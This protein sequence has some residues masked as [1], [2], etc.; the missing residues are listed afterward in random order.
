MENNPKTP[1]DRIHYVSN[2]IAENENRMSRLERLL[3]A[4]HA[5]GYEYQRAKQRRAYRRRRK[6]ADYMNQ[7]LKVIRFRKVLEKF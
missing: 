6:H 5:L 4:Y 7:N 2:F 1:A 3:L